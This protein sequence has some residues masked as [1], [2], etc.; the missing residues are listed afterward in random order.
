MIV[1]N[2]IIIETMGIVT[3]QQNYGHGLT[4]EV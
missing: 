1:V 2:G 3:I 4:M